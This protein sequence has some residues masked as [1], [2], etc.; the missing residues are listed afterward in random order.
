MALLVAPRAGHPAA[1]AL[2]LLDLEPH[3]LEQL[4]LAGDP[5]GR[6]VMAV[7]VEE[8]IPPQRRRFPPLRALAEEVREVEG[9]LAE[10]P[11]VLVVRQHL[12]QL[13]LEDGD[14]A[15]LDPDDRHARA[16][17]VA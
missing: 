5:T 2:Q 11:R 16:D 10:A 14:A 13:V 9:L 6:A 4:L 12:R 17:L 7:A 15:R 3:P 1:A 8:R